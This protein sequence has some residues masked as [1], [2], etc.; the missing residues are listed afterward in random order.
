MPFEY[1]IASY[2]LHLIGLFSVRY[3]KIVLTLNWSRKEENLCEIAN[4][5]LKVLLQKHRRFYETTDTARH[6]RVLLRV[7]L[8]RQKQIARKS[9]ITFRTP[10]HLNKET[11]NGL[12]Y[13]RIGNVILTLYNYGN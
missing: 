6:Q 8:L 12:N 11:G 3:G 9:K 10:L 13:Q 7:L 2:T 5:L 1:Y 4:K